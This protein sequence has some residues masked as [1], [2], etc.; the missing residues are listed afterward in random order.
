MIT[1]EEVRQ[2]MVPSINLILNTV[3]LHIMSA[4]NLG[5]VSTKY[6][7]P[8][9]AVPHIDGIVKTLKDSGFR[10]TVNP[11]ANRGSEDF[12]ILIGW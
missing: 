7:V 8:P 11:V 2:S 9:R 3:E 4:K 1:A 6:E 10:V 12:D 5:Y